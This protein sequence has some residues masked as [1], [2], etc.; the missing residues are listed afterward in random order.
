MYPSNESSGYGLK[1]LE[2]NAC[3]EDQT[4]LQILETIFKKKKIIIRLC[5]FNTSDQINTVLKICNSDRST[6]H[7]FNY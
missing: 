7:A 6:R 2:S 1:Y 4:M 5:L 3:L